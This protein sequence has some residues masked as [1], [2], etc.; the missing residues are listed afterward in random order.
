MAECSGPGYGTC[1]I[2]GVTVHMARH[3]LAQI[4]MYGNATIRQSES[5]W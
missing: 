4:R 3:H 1:L 2:N 5:R